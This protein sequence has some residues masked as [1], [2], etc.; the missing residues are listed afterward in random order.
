MEA[1]AEAAFAK[2]E[3]LGQAEAAGLDSMPQFALHIIRQGYE[4]V[5]DRTR[6]KHGTGMDDATMAYQRRLKGA[7][8]SIFRH[9][10]KSHSV[11]IAKV[12]ALMRLAAWQGG[13]PQEPLRTLNTLFTP[14][15]NSEAMANRAACFDFYEALV[16]YAR[17]Q[18]K[19]DRLMT[20]E[21]MLECIHKPLKPVKTLIEWLQDTLAKPLGDVLHG[22][23]ASGTIAD[24][25]E[26]IQKALDLVT[27]RV[28]EL[29]N[30]DQDQ[31]PKRRRK[32]ATV[33]ASGEGAAA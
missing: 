16:R 26:Q 22:R 13:G 2:C 7:N 27:A 17:R 28:E 4:G 19:M 5:F 9:K 33:E 24:D 11:Q 14:L 23:A 32:T 29:R 25:S 15:Y 1:V 10:T 31:K 20:R 8:K 3:E 12:N 30:Q 6:N 18:Y 21:E